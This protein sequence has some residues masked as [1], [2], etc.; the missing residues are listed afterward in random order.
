MAET[1]T[2][3]SEQAAPSARWLTMLSDAETAEK[4]YQDTCSRVE[5]LYADL[6]RLKS[7]VHDREYQIFWAN[8]QT[9]RPAVYTK[10]P[11][12]VVSSRFRDRKP[13][14]RRAA[15]ILERALAADIEADE[16]HET[17]L[18]ARDDLSL[19]ARGVLRIR[20][21]ER[22]GIEVPVAEHVDR[23][24]FRHEPAR[25][26]KEV[27]WVAFCGWLTRDEVRERFGRV[28]EGMSFAERDIGGTKGKERKAGVWEIWHRAEGKVVFVTGGVE[29][30]LEEREPWLD[31]TGFFP[32]P[33][34]AYGTIR[35]RTMLPVP[36]YAFYRDQ[37]EEINELTG[38]VASLT[39]SL[40]LKGFYAG[41]HAEFGEAI[42]QAMRSLDN[43]ALLV[44]VSTLAL[45]TASIA[46]SILWLPIEQVASVI[47][48]CLALRRQLIEDVYQITGLS[49]I[50]RGMS[51]ASETATAQR[52]KSQ[53]G[54]VRVRERQSEMVRLAR[55]VIRLK[56]EIMAEKLPMDA[57]LTMAQVDDLP[58]AADIQKQVQGIIQQTQAQIAPLVQ[59][60]QQMAA[61]GQDVSQLEQQ[62]QQ[63]AQQ[64][65]Q[66]VQELQGQITVEAIEKMLRDQ[67]L[68]PFVLDIETDSTVEADQMLEKQ[69]R[70][71]FTTALGPMLQQ[72]VQAMQMAPQLGPFV[73][74]SI[75]YMASGFKVDRR[76][77]EAIDEL[78]EGLVNYQP[79]QQPGGEDPEAAKMTAQAEQM[80]A[81]ASAEMA[82][83]KAQEAGAKVQSMQADMQLRQQEAQLAAQKTAVEIEKLRA[84][85]AKIGADMQMGQQKAAVDMARGEQ[86]AAL[87]EEKTRADMKRADV[88]AEVSAAKTQADTKRADMVAKQPKGPAR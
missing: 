28:P 26:W 50:M 51:D 15:D 73:A 33:R 19:N 84:E 78:A 12:P 83:A 74:E 31:L 30:I 59:Q 63:I 55:D 70:V 36:D 82:Q 9:L 14:P 42:E 4:S 44:P 77:D 62:G 86:Q 16:L 54:S 25:K 39:E 27:G 24:D 6:D 40:R 67:R 60:G 48:Q 57:L 17:L 37:I 69:A 64:A 5:K 10:P 11:V 79:P 65:Q 68:R 22:D 71:E 43:R 29:E 75:R 87:A 23:K 58:R 49:D 32:C 52:L 81:Q 34:P 61:Q 2:K 88:Q 76:M 7:D 13:L 20:M 1:D 47:E 45:G 38:R 56:A 80:K 8:I 21:D 85:I 72:A 18:S 46:D 53:Y 41:G 3:P 66:Q 35:P